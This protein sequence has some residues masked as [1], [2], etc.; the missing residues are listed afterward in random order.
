MMQTIQFASDA[1]ALTQFLAVSLRLMALMRQHSCL[2]LSIPKHVHVQLNQE[3]FGR[4]LYDLLSSEYP[5]LEDRMVIRVH[6]KTD[7]LISI[8][9]PGALHEIT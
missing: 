1:P 9:P 8:Q 6:P 5:D 2:Y 3:D 4:V 7:F